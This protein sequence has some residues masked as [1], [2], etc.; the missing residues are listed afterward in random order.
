[1]ALGLGMR[2]TMGIGAMIELADQFHRPIE[3]VQV[4][5]AVIADVHP[6]ATGPTTAIEDVEFPRHE[7]GICRPPVGHRAGL[8]VLM[9]SSDRRIRTRGYARS[10]AFPSHLSGRCKIWTMVHPYQVPALARAY[11]TVPA[12]GSRL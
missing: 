9:E 11:L 1:G 6:A 7:I 4:A 8:Q 10:L 2:G 12:H 3:G 5:K